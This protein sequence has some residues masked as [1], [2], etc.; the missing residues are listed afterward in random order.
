MAMVQA[1][2]LHEGYN[3]NELIKKMPLGIFRSSAIISFS[4]EVFRVETHSVGPHLDS[5]ITAAH[6]VPIL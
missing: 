5:W 4:L 3:L 1:F 6:I 2:L